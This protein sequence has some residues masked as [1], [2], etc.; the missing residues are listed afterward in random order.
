MESPSI[1]CTSVSPK[2]S[3]SAWSCETC[4]LEQPKN[5]ET[6]EIIKQSSNTDECVE[7]NILTPPQNSQPISYF[8]QIF[9]RMSKLF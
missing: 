2:S 1:I 4:P 7:T 9:T 8:R 5:T 3:C 6:A